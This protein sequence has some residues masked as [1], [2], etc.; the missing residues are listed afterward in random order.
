M[1]IGIYILYVKW[2]YAYGNIYYKHNK[3]ESLLGIQ[4]DHE[5]FS[6]EM[7]KELSFGWQ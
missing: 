3:W 7:A 4:I 2:F 5:T 1:K 6:K